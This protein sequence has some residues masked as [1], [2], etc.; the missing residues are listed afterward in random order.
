MQQKDFYNTGESSKVPKSKERKT[1][2]NGKRKVQKTEIQSQWNNNWK[3]SRLKG[4]LEHELF[5]KDQ[6]S[7]ATER[8]LQHRRIAED[9]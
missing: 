7:N 9:S 2:S 4:E 3:Y 1:I 8:L 5:L 6:L